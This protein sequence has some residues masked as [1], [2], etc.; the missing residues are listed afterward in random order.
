MLRLGIY[1][2]IVAWQDTGITVHKHI[3][4][5]MCADNAWDVLAPDKHQHPRLFK[6]TLMFL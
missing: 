3:S 1:F 2:E 5:K 4:T 6:H